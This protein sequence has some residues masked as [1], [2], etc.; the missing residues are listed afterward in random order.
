[1]NRL[2]LPG[3]ESPFSRIGFGCMRLS[4]AQEAEWFTQIDAYLRLGGN[5]FDTAEVYGNGDSETALGEYIRRRG[6]R[7]DV[8]I[9]TKGC[10]EPRLVRPDYIRGAIE[11]SL[12]RLKTDVV[13]LYLLHRDDPTVPVA[14]LLDVLNEAVK[15]G[16][17]RAFGGS[18][19]TAARL[20]EANL[21]AAR[22]GMLGFSVSSPHLALATPRE[23]WWP[24]CTH[25]TKEDMAW[26]REQGMVVLAW[27]SQCRGFLGQ[28]EITDA[29]YLADLVRVYYT[30]ANLEKRSRLHELAKRRGVLP[31]QLAV[32]Y[33]LAVHAQTVALV[34][35]VSPAELSSL[36]EAEQIQLSQSERLWLEMEGPKPQ[37]P[38]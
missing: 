36:M 38:S 7:S 27:S 12:E 34:G 13:D 19:W 6:D 25:A 22:N 37:S 5:L 23:P 29:A 1:M 32:A 8:V 28:A 30:P 15:Q 35:P 24:S 17:I 14:E 18:N 16:K 2:S 3:L 20:R 31:S 21:L 10:V 4:L 11:R 26:Y 9:V 33:V